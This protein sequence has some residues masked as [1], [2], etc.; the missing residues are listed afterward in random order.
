[1]CCKLI[2]VNTFPVLPCFREVWDI[3]SI[4]IDT[5]CEFV[6]VILCKQGA[7][8]QE[9]RFSDNSDNSEKLGS[10]VLSFP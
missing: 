7:K 3:S 9:E 10:L 4:S 8:V 5:Q 6:T 2:N 1:M